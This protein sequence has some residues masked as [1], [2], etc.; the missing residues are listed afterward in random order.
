MKYTD[1]Q[2][3]K[4]PS[5]L[6]F[7]KQLFIGLLSFSFLKKAEA[8]PR[9]EVKL[10]VNKNFLIPKE[11]KFWECNTSRELVVINASVFDRQTHRVFTVSSNI[12]EEA[13]LTK[14]VWDAECLKLQDAARKYFAFHDK[15]PTINQIEF[16]GK[17]EI[18][19]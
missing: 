15:M 4:Y 19:S 12:L 10:S 9:F 11:N 5:R 17:P 16:L 18:I 6:Q 8:K 1:F 13:S 3:I 7:F 2:K 14:E